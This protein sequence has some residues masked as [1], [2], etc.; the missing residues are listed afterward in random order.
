MATVTEIS[1]TSVRI[2]VTATGTESWYLQYNQRN[3]AVLDSLTY[4]L[5]FRARSLGA[6]R[7]L[8]VSLSMAEGTY[9]NLGL[10]GSYTLTS[11]WQT[12]KMAGPATQSFNNSRVSFSFASSSAT[13]ELA[14]VVLAE[15]VCD[16]ANDNMRS[17]NE[18]SLS[19][20]SG[21]A[22]T[23]TRNN[24]GIGTAVVDITALGTA[25][26]HIMFGVGGLHIKAGVHYLVNFVASSTTPLLAQIAV[27]GGVKGGGTIYSSSCN[28]TSAD[29]ACGFSFAATANT[30]STF[31]VFLGTAV[32]TV[33]LKQ[34]NIAEDGCTGLAAGESINNVAPWPALAFETRARWIDRQLFIAFLER[35]YWEEMRTHIKTTLGYKGLVTGTIQFGPIA[36]WGQA[37]MDFIDDHSYW[38]HPSFPGIPWSSTDWYITQ[39]PMSLYPTSATFWGLVRAEGRPF[40]VTE[41][42]HAAPIDAQAEAVP[43][44]AAWA[45]LQDLDGIFL[46]A[47]SHGDHVF[48]SHKM[49]GFFDIDYNPAKW[50]FMKAASLI[51]QK[52]L[53]PRNSAKRVIHVASS[54]SDLSAVLT[55]LADKQ[56]TGSTSLITSDWQGSTFQ[57]WIRTRISLDYGLWQS[58]G[59]SSS[60]TEDPGVFWNASVGFSA[61]SSA[62]VLFSGTNNAT[63]S[64]Y[65]WGSAAITSPALY[66]LA[67][68]PLDAK[69]LAKSESLLFV[70]IGRVENT[71]MVW[72]A[73][74]T[75][76]TN[77]WGTS[78]ALAEVVEGTVTINGAGIAGDSCSWQPLNSSGVPTR[79]EAL[80]LAADGSITINLVADDA[81]V[82]YVL[83]CTRVSEPSST[84]SADD[85]V[86]A[87]TTALAS[88]VVA[89]SAAM[90]SSLML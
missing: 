3:I 88:F 73:E 44:I 87:A 72:N 64:A 79:T 37:D 6:N 58:S 82:W 2:E 68:V 10:S 33:T 81:T 35:N 57:D 40:T 15:S 11:S 24:G 23:L 34:A 71:G 16:L 47:Y 54:S 86:S 30:T 28:I 7:P 77:Q 42:N 75:S 83:R 67:L 69:P 22:A 14:D 39:K 48:T 5:S 85:N 12:F 26:W 61:W 46:F 41:Y 1:S 80:S 36:M 66:S 74:R 43:M 52:A 78:P 55:Q 51:Y 4:V 45:A 18:W 70:A 60:A 49:N 50:C 13:F 63:A 84:G 8:S 20:F 32:A 53:I 65:E 31:Q 27:T 90:M 89:S 9:A 25:N 38:Q 19:T 62:A 21:A 29:T 17:W 59:D 56:G 76:V